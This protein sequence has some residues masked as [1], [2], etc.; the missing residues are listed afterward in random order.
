[1]SCHPVRGCLIIILIVLAA[2]RLF[3]GPKPQTWI[4]LRS[5]N[6]TIVTNDNENQ[7]RHLAYQFEMVRAVFREFFGIS[8]SSKDQPVIIIAA[9]D[10]DTLKTLL[11]EYWAKKGSAH[12]AGIYFGSLEKNYIALRLDV[13]MNQSAYEPYEIVYHEYVHHL[14]RRLR[15]VMPLWLVEGLAEF[16][17]NI[18]IERKNVYV[19]APSSS[20]LMVLR[21]NPP[22]PLSTLFDVNATSPYYHEEDKA[23][24]FYAESWALTHYLITRDWREKT[25]RVND[26]IDLLGQNVPEAE[27]VRRTIGDPAALEAALSQYIRNVTFTAMSLDA[28]KIDESDFGIL[29]ISDAE[30]L[31]VR[32]DFMVR[33]RHYAE[34]QQMLE[35]SLKLD[36]KLA[37]AYESMGFLCSQQGKTAEAG[38]WY[39]EAIAL[40]SQSYSANYYYA[41]NLL[42]GRLDDDWAAKAE[43]SLRVVLKLNPDFAPA[44]S[45]LA[46]LLAQASPRQNPDEA[47]IL[48][49]RA[50]ELEPGNVQYRVRAVQVLERLE[51]TE[52]AVR[53][54]KLAVSLAKTPQEHAEASAALSSAQQFLAYHN[55]ANV[56]D[57]IFFDYQEAMAASNEGD[58]TRAIDGFK[59]V[60]ALNPTYPSAWNEL[61]RIYLLQD[62]LES[63]TAAFRKQIQ[64]NSLDF[65][66]YNNLGLTLERQEKWEEAIQN[67]RRQLEINPDDRN[68]HANLGYLLETR[69]DY[70]RAIPELQKAIS[71]NP[72]NAALLVALANAYCQSAQE[73]KCRST[74]NDAARIADTPLNWNNIAWYTAVRKFKLDEALKY[75]QRA[76]ASIE[77][78]LSGVSLDHITNQDLQKVSSLASYWDT[79]GWVYFQ[80]GDLPPAERYLSAAWQLRHDGVIGDHL[81]QLYEKLGR[82]DD[83]VRYYSLSLGAANPEA[84]TRDRLIALA[85][86][87]AVSDEKL[88]RYHNEL[89][90]LGFLQVA[91]AGAVDAVADFYVA[92]VPGPGPMIPDV[93]FIC[94]NENLKSATDLLRSASYQVSFPDSQPVKLIRR[95]EA[96]CSAGDKRCSLKLVSPS[97]AS[98][99]SSDR[100][101]ALEV[102]EDTMGVDFSSYTQMLIT[103][104]R[105]NWHKLIPRKAQ[106]PEMKKGKVS[107]GFAIQQNGK[108]G[109]ID[110]S[111][112][113]GDFELDRAAF[114]AIVRSAPFSPLPLGF[115][116]SSLSFRFHFFYN[117]GPDSCAKDD[118]SPLADNSVSTPAPGKDVGTAGVLKVGRGASAPR[119]V[120]LSD[121]EY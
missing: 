5:P 84:G 29:S 93:K 90:E 76:V 60:I 81:G 70:D 14:T 71:L 86:K 121:P 20:R 118:S 96:A 50:I 68:A 80:R 9:K 18:R 59:Q 43:S 28:P 87:D 108:L 62:Q 69:R 66:A 97:V 102:L 8:G 116:R 91:R 24:I 56:S 99:E 83:G 41:A 65:F 105:P 15:S 103:T 55:I 36:P 112:S 110:I 120:Y 33:D 101:S 119:P 44:Y 25:H 114:D 63:A 117:P 61:G 88:V 38:K 57:P 19:G 42:T 78:S 16:Y 48:V 27:A 89:A 6:F 115:T 74:L 98:R 34:A 75:A 95:V 45:T 17:G 49:L 54:G 12:P 109:H 37:A 13:S 82:K 53:V 40:N 113:S 26:L 21:Q 52:D 47:Y 85:G 11:P 46:Y 4:E 111:R 79:L 104:V 51:R 106:A 22:L 67:F 58:Y 107:I 77:A 35:E 39:S 1:M 7:A 73:E 100:P 2:Q 3:S 92:F 23:S 94:G 32:A 10:E 72:N 30:S 31:A 64:I